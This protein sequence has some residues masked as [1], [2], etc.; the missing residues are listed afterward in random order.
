MKSVLECLT[1]IIVTIGSHPPATAD[2]FSAEYVVSA[3]GLRIGKSSFSTTMDKNKYTINGSL[4]AAGLATLFSSMSGQL[5]VTGTTGAKHVTP[6]RYDVRYHEGDKKKRTTI[7][8]SNGKIGKVT[9]QPPLRK[10]SNWVDHK[11]G[12]LN[13]AVDPIT[14]TIIPASNAGEVCRRT[15]RVFDGAMRADIVLSPLRQIPYSTNGYKGEAVICR[16]RFLPVSGYQTDKKDIIFMRDKS[17]IEISFAPVGTT[18]FWAPVMARAST[19]IGQ[20]TVRATR[21]DTPDP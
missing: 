1:T 18:G 7:G 3:I 5:T 19:R 12:A 17:N 13:A 20:I 8:F 6:S 11:P 14:A 10:K 15:I 9:N 4:N 2:T 16:A 21:F